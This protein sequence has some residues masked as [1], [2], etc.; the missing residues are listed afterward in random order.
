MNIL[1]LIPSLGGGGSERQLVLLAEQ[2]VR[3]GHVVTV[4]TANGGVWRTALEQSGAAVHVVANR[5]S[6]DPRILTGVAALVRES[7]ADVVHTWLRQ[8]D[9]CGGTAAL[10]LK[11]PW[12][13]SERSSER[14]YPE[15]FK[16]WMRRTLARHASAIV[17]NSEPGDGY[18]ERHVG[19]RVRRFVIPNAVDF[20]GID[21]VSASVP[22]EVPAGLAT[23]LFG[24]RLE[25]EKNLELLLPALE[26]VVAPGD[27][28][29]LLC[30]TG[31]YEQRVRDWLHT[32]GLDQHIRLLGFRQDLWQIMKA[33]AALVS[34]SRFEGHPNTVMEAMA[35]GCPIVAS[36]I[37][38][39]RAFLDPETAL[40]VPVDDADAVAAAIRCVIDSPDAARRRAVNARR[41]AEQYS[42]ERAVCAYDEVYAAVLSAN[43]S[44][45]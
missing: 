28:Q 22:A 43:G 16:H 35:C 45:T 20:D 12:V 14:A 9:V 42:A 33:A 32:R 13:L 29:A 37:P 30:G 25:A 41:R 23:I 7:D 10:A 38:A 24:G 31:P 39:H 44:G 1:H 34:I 19:R 6:H 36:D 26:Q 17:S 2:Q 15:S 8:M 40:L 4:G 18:W 5:G 21:R 27:A 11:R 3:R